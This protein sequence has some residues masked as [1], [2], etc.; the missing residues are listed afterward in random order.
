[1]QRSLARCGI[2]VLR[3]WAPHWRWA[4][5]S[6]EPGVHRPHAMA[7]WERFKAF[8]RERIASGLGMAHP[9]QPIEDAV[10]SGKL[11]GALPT[12]VLTPSPSSV[13]AEMSGKI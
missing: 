13:G 5:R 8:T 3:Q 4:S 6:R 12:P 9:H 10:F 7:G 1:M 2:V 11:S